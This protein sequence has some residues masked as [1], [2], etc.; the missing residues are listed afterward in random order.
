MVEERR[1]PLTIAADRLV[2]KYTVKRLNLYRR[3]ATSYAYPHSDL[4]QRCDRPHENTVTARHPTAS[5]LR[6]HPPV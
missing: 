2:Q 5:G 4:G 3:M 1:E 6:T